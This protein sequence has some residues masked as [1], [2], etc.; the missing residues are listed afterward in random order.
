MEA[1]DLY[2]QI[3]TRNRKWSWRRPIPQGLAAY[4][5]SILIRAGVGGV[6]AAAFAAS[7]QISGPLGAFGLGVGALLI[8]EKIARIAAAQTGRTLRS[9]DL[10]YPPSPQELPESSPAPSEP[11]PEARGGAHA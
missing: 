1:V 5:V 2:R 11:A 8:V 7:D 4:M 6:L 9:T 3:H 10:T